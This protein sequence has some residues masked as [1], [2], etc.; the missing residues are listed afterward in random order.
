[1]LGSCTSADIPK[2]LDL[3][4]DFVLT[5]L[6]CPWQPQSAIGQC[7]RQVSLTVSKFKEQIF[8]FDGIIIAMLS[9]AA[10]D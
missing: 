5:F 1:M 4:P 2:I 6:I 3:K 9:A 7:K 8:E 10:H